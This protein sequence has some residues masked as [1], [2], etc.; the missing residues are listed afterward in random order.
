[1]T[2]GEV[3]TAVTVFS[4]TV[5]LAQFAPGLVTLAALPRRQEVLVGTDGDRLPPDL[6]R[7]NTPVCRIGVPGW[8]DS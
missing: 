2:I 6:L 3:M 4:G 7:N 5:P 8:K 1:M